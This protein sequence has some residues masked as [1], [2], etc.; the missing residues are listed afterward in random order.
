M[1]TT[2]DLTVEITQPLLAAM[3][4]AAR[5]APKKHPVRTYE[6]IRITAAGNDLIIEAANSDVHYQ[7][8]L[9]LP[10]VT[11]PT[12][13]AAVL[14]RDVV[15]NTK[16]P[17]TLQF[18]D[19]P[20]LG[21]IVLN[22]EILP[23]DFLK[24]PPEPTSE[25][26]NC[27]RDYFDALE[28][29]AL[30]AAK[31]KAR[32]MLQGICHRGDSL[33]ASDGLSAYWAKTNKSWPQDLVL[34]ASYAATL[35]KLF[36]YSGAYMA[37]N[38]S[39][40][41]YWRYGHKIAIRPLVR[42]VDGQHYPDVAGVYPRTTAVAH[43]TLDRKA[44]I[45][46]LESVI[47]LYKLVKRRDLEF[48]MTIEGFIEK[49][50]ISARVEGHELQQDVPCQASKSFWLRL[51]AQLLHQALQQLDDNNEVEFEF[52]SSGTPFL[53]SQRNGRRKA[54]IAVVTK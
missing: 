30:S 13:A 17:T 34:P 25:V 26:I 5:L 12:P 21:P 24:A 8:T 31:S 28:H 18:G 1:T 43:G 51:N 42:P 29:A 23:E 19:R 39:H 53:L 6:H 50:V 38:D 41:W 48:R 40:I 2:T 33:F 7:R 4:T 35:G 14:H 49:A 32:P 44:W 46:A 52:Y 37:W 3:K 47:S 16:A 54:L 10:D 20:R 36:G 9:F 45:Q 11:M 15:L 22:P 27:D